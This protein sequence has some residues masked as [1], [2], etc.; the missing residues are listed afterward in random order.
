MY[1]HLLILAQNMLKIEKITRY[2]YRFMNKNLKPFL[3]VRR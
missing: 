2:F 1:F 3:K